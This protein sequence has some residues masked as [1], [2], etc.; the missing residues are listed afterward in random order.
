MI[1]IIATDFEQGQILEGTVVSIKEFG[2]FIE[3]LLAKREWF[4]FLRLQ[5]RESTE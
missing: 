2:A 3:L 4:T 1:K 5:K